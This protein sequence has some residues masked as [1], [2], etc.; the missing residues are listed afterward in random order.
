MNPMIGRRYEFIDF[1]SNL[2]RI[3]AKLEGHMGYRDAERKITT[4]RIN[5]EYFNIIVQWLKP[6][7]RC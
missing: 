1:L 6:V 5:I 3:W 7:L 4:L 2:T